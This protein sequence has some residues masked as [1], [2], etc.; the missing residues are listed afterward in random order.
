[1]MGNIKSCTDC[2]VLFVPNSLFTYIIQYLKLN[3]KDLS[4]FTG[5][6]NL[7]LMLGENKKKIV[8]HEPEARY[9]PNIL[10]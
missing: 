4:K 10:A 6:I 2:S 3:K 7:L 1:M 9:Y 5:V 8:N